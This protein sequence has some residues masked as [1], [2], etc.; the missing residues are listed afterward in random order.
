MQT[1]A[2][3]KN[4]NYINAEEIKQYKIIETI[5]FDNMT[6][7]SKVAKET[8]YIKKEILPDVILDYKTM[9]RFIQEYEFITICDHPNIIKAYGMHIDSEGKHSIIIE[10]CPYKLTN[11]IK[12]LSDKTRISI[13]L[14]IASAM[15]KIHSN[16]I[17]H[18]NLL[19]ENILLDENQHAKLSNFGFCT[20]FDMEEDTLNVNHFVGKFV[21]PPPELMKKNAKYDEKIDV[22][23]FGSILYTILTKGENPDISYEEIIKRI[24]APIPNIITPFSTLL[25]QRCWSYDAKDRPSF[26]DIFETISKNQNKLI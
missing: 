23:A 1:N 13:I 11:M 2:K 14:E 8:N 26:K 9:K 12:K 19:I 18:R 17:I 6:K 16:K 21:I 3:D 20:F 24:I 15:E 5:D 4:I 22:Y 7:T 10:Y 25:I